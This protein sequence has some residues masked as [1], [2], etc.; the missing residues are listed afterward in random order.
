MKKII[1]LI[2]ALVLLQLSAPALSDNSESCTV[3]GS[4][5]IQYPDNSLSYTD[6]YCAAQPDYYGLTFYEMGL[7]ENAPT[8]PTTS[9]NIDVSACSVVMTSDAGSL[10]EIRNGISGS[11]G[12]TQTRP[13]NGTYNYGYIRLSND[14]L[15]EASLEFWSDNIT[16]ANLSGDYT[17]GGSTGKYCATRAATYKND[18]SSGTKSTICASSAP[19]A[20]RLTAQLVDFTGGQASG[21]KSLQ[22]CG[23]AIAVTGGTLNAYLLDSDN[24]LADSG[25]TVTG[26]IGVQ[27][28]TNPVVITDNTASMDA[29][30][31]VTKAMTVSPGSDGAN[32][33]SASFDSGPFSVVMTTN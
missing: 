20:G 10:V 2:S 13:A 30:I 11:L 7:C 29:A 5:A 21:C 22:N 28:F 9:A 26:L 3:N 16:V 14:F 15:M 27:S 19:T 24:N 6:G 31:I 32:N 18:G 1:S 4:N 8:A 33:I 17:T 12:G 23:G 25:D